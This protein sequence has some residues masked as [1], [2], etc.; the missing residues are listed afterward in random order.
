MPAC[1]GF[2]RTG[3]QCAATVEPPQAFCWWHDPANA[4]QRS[5][6][7]SRAARSK[8]HPGELA[9]VKAQLRTIA[10]DVLEGR[11]DKGKGSVAAQVLGVYVRVVEAERKIKEQDELVERLDVLEQ[12]QEQ[13]GGGYG[14]G[15]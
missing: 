13:R 5:R 12:V 14:W 8:A 11:L 10:A 2:K 15:R 4:D 1:R 9:D 7:A 6:A 3:E